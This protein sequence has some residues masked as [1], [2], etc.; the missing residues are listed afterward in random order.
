MII[1][2]NVMLS[3]GVIVPGSGGGAGGGR[4]RDG[5]GVQRLPLSSPSSFLQ[6]QSGDLVT[7]GRFTG[8]RSLELQPGND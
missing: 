5:P 4:S 8:Q 6:S 1:T 2:V 3:R 7:P